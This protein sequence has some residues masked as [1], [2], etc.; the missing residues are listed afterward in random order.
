[1]NKLTILLLCL[2]FTLTVMI[3]SCSNSLDVTGRNGFN[4]AFGN[5]VFYADSAIYISKGSAGVLG[6][7]IYAYSGGRIAFAFYLNPPDTVGT[8][9]LDS[10]RNSVAYYNPTSSP[11]IDPYNCYRSSSGSLTITQYYN[12]SLKVINGYF[13]F[14]GVIPGA[15][16]NSLY[17]SYGNFNNIPRRY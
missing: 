16:G 12:D 15:S 6:T 2:A 11:T 9:Q 14:N 7:N 1:M 4:C 13:S 10:D 17:F 8:F 5:K 3:S